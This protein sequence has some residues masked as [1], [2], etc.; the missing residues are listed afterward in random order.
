MPAATA[1]Q[2]LKS[3]SLPPILGK[4]T[5]PDTS[6]RQLEIRCFQQASQFPKWLEW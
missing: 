6:G 3:G 4:G 5:G 2:L 1:L